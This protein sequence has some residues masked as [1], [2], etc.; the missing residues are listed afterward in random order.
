MEG[1]CYYATTKGTPQGGVV[2]PILAN[3]Y[4]HYLLDKW[5]LRE[6]KPYCIGK[7]EMIRYCDDFVICTETK[8]D[9]DDI[10]YQLEQRLEK[11]KL[12]LSKEKTKVVTFRPPD[13]RNGNGKA[14]TF[15]FLG[16]TH[17]WE[18]SRKGFYKI[19]R[20]TERKRFAK[21][22][23]MVKRWLEG[24]R[25]RLP[26][27]EIWKRTKQMLSGHYGYYGVSD[28][29]DQLQKYLY[30]VESLLFKWLNR[31]SQ[32]RSFN[33]YQFAVYKQRYPLP[34]PRIYHKFY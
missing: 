31:R 25:N 15:N 7:V 6:V 4:L 29:Y 9:A 17:Y 28:N 33:W 2:S 21:A 23:F 19:S 12:R 22:V 18:K 26:L 10:L 30:L 1:R 32:R 13:D 14:G 20:R 5:F 16:F 27:K 34:K 3:I 24:N 8:A 11:G